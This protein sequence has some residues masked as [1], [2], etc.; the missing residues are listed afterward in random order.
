MQMVFIVIF[1][2]DTS[3]PIKFKTNMPVYVLGTSYMA[4]DKRR[5][6]NNEELTIHDPEFGLLMSMIYSQIWL[7]YRSGFTP[8]HNSTMK[9]DMGWGCMIRSLQMMIARG[10]LNIKAG[11]SKNNITIFT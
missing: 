1:I 4:L 10:L 8:L 9:T 6:V 3:K 7:T 5:N 2:V 11:R